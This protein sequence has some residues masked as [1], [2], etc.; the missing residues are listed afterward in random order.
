MKTENKIFIIVT[1]ISG[2]FYASMMAGFDYI[3]GEEFK[4]WKYVFHFTFFGLLMG[5]FARYNH[6]KQFKKVNSDT[7]P[8]TDK[9]NS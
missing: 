6:K 8:P 5:F 9:T 2:I 3:T 7:L 1:L 4:I